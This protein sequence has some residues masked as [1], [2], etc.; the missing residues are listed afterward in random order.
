MDR[1]SVERSGLTVVNSDISPPAKGVR[2]ALKFAGK[3]ACK[4]MM[5]EDAVMAKD[6]ITP[7]IEFKTTQRAMSQRS[8][9]SQGR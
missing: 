2:K 1:I 6:A 4:A 3:D 7:T 9:Y 8:I 5:A